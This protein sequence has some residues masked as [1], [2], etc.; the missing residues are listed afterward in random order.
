MSLLGKIDWVGFCKR[1]KELGT[2]PATSEIKNFNMPF[3][4]WFEI[5]MRKVTQ[6]ALIHWCDDVI[7]H[8]EEKPL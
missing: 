6:E 3:G 1:T 8:Y 4:I 5:A 2:I 7:K